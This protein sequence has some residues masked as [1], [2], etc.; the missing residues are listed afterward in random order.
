MYLRS[1]SAAKP[2]VPLKFYANVIGKLTISERELDDE[3]ADRI[4]KSTAAAAEKRHNPKTKFIDANNLP[5]PT[6]K[7]AAK[8][9][10]DLFRKP[11]RPSDRLKP[12]PL[13]TSTSSAPSPRPSHAPK[14]PQDGT[15]SLGRRLIHYLA[16]AER[17]SEDAVKAV[18]GSNCDAKTRQDILDALHLV[19]S[20]YSLNSAESDGPFIACRTRTIQ[21]RLSADLA[22]E[23]RVLA[24]RTAV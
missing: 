5:Q 14:P 9:K 24:R 23:T 10:S 19:R 7:S 1:A 21:Q 12:T 13:S 17:T 22:F 8:K 15:T 20:H 6:T 2:F 11:L 16:L 4:R 18:G 3:L